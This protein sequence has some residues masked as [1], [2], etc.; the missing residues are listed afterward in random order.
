MVTFSGRTP[1]LL[2]IL[3][4][5]PQIP[6][7]V[8]SSCMEASECLILASRPDGVLLPTPIHESEIASFGH[9][10][11]TSSTT[12]TMVLGD[13]LALVTAQKAHTTPGRSPA[14]VFLSNHPGG[15]IGQAFAS[16]SQNIEA[17]ATIIDEIPI[18][19]P[20]ENTT[21]MVLD[22]ILTAVRSPSGW[23][24]LSPTHV[25]SPRKIRMLH[26]IDE[27]ID[28]L[29]S[30]HLVVEMSDWISILGSW[31][32]TE[33]KQWIAKMRIES[34][35]RAFLK[36][37]TILGVVDGNQQVSSVLEIEAVPG[38]HLDDHE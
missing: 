4:Y 25:I 26:N 23:V 10:A 24:R 1:E 18:V 11:P 9:A 17:I 33:T 30:K 28:P 22:V 38:L 32:V 8:M 19:V 36:Q 15:A 16:K 27:P 13:A 34:R 31:T 21:L 29:H 2:N 37:G 3:P 7:V 12:V 14:E 5:L 20:R 6:I 35:G